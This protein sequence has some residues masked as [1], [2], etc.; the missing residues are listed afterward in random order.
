MPTFNRVFENQPIPSG[1]LTQ[2]SRY[3]R[4]ENKL[5]ADEKGPQ[6]GDSVGLVA[7]IYIYTKGLFF[8]NMFWGCDCKVH[9]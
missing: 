2:P 7:W 4:A 6:Q 5:L 8:Q 9:F 3:K 1:I